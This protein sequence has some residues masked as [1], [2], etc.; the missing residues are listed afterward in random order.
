MTHSERISAALQ[1][2]FSALSVATDDAPMPQMVSRV[3]EL[4]AKVNQHLAKMG[5][6]WN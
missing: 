1:E 4:E 3:S 5:F 2:K 6:A